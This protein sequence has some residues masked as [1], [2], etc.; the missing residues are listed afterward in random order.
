M[1]VDTR[2]RFTVNQCCKVRGIRA[3][4]ACNGKGK[5][6]SGNVVPY[7][8]REWILASDVGEHGGGGVD[9]ETC[10]FRA[11]I[12]PTAQK[13]MVTREAKGSER[14]DRPAVRG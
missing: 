6:A 10:R 5:F 9:D 2:V 4:D 12:S 13:V 1:E 11:Y 3:Y 7:L 14:D 8:A